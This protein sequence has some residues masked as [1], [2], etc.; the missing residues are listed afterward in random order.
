MTQRALRPSGARWVALLLALTGVAGANGY[1]PPP[2]P[3]PFSVPEGTRTVPDATAG[4]TGIP[5]AGL[6]TAET[7]VPTQGLT[8][9]ADVLFGAA[10]GSDAAMPAAAMPLP[11]FRPPLPAE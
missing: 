8:P 9:R 4:S 3:Y 2:G 6:P 5:A 7:V 1:P 11:I 10:P